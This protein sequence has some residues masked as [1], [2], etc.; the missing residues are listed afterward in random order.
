M[1]LLFICTSNRL[2]SPTAETYF[3]ADKRYETRS[4]GTDAEATLV[5]SQ[6]MV[7]WAD[8]IFVMERRHRKKLE[9]QFG[10]RLDTD[11][12]ITL[13]I[14]D[15]YERDDPVLIDLLELRVRPW[16]EDESAA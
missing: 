10:D 1:K 5:V 15:E 16:L 6:A 12:V 2:R 3:G 4:A 8:L 14:P 7:E 11:K 9:K 13:G